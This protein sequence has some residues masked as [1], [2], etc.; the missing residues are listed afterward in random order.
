M[1]RGLFSA[2]LLATLVGATAEPATAQTFNQL[3]EDLF[4][5]GGRGGGRP[6]VNEPGMSRETRMQV[7]AGL[8][9]AGFY[10]GPIDGAIGQG[11]RAAI[12]RWQEANGIRPT[13]LL[14]RSEIARLR[15]LAGSFDG[16]MGGI[17][18]FADSPLDTPLDGA[19]LPLGRSETAELQRRLNELGYDAGSV[20]GRWGS[21][22]RQALARFREETGQPG[23]AD[24]T[25]AALVTVRAATGDGPARSAP[26]E[27]PPASDYA[28]VDSD[29]RPIDEVG[30][31]TLRALA[32]QAIAADPALVD[33][34]DEVLTFLGADDTLLGSKQVAEYRQANEFDRPRI[35]SAARARILL[36]AEETPRRPLKVAVTF[37]ASLLDFETGRGFPLEISSATVNPPNPLLVVALDHL[38]GRVTAAAAGLPALDLLPL[39]EKEGESFLAKLKRRDDLIGVVWADI[40]AEDIQED[41]ASER[42]RLS[43]TTTAASLHTRGPRVGT[44]PRLVLG[45]TLYRWRLASDRPDAPLGSDVLGLARELR[46][47]VVQDHL[48]MPS[49]G[50]GDDAVFN[51]LRV[52]SGGVVRAWQRLI[53]YMVLNENPALAESDENV[54]TLAAVHGRRRTSGQLNFNGPDPLRFA[55]EFERKAFLDRS[56]ADLIPSLLARKVPYPMPAAMISAVSL[57]EYDFERQGFS[58]GA[59]RSDAYPGVGSS[60]VETLFQG[61]LQL[62]KFLPMGVEEGKRFRRGLRGNTPT[63]Y[64]LTRFEITE[65]AFAQANSRNPNGMVLVFRLEDSILYADAALSNAIHRFGTAEL[66]PT[67][68]AP[69]ITDAEAL[70]GSL[71]LVTAR[72]LLD[73]AIRNGGGEPLAERAAAQSQVVK[74]AN[75]FDRSAALE[76]EKAAILRYKAA[77]ELWTAGE[78]VLAEYDGTG[79]PIP[80]STQTFQNDNGSSHVARMVNFQISNP[81]AIRR[82]DVDRETAKAGRTAMGNRRF[83]ILHRIR[84]VGVTADGDRSVVLVEALETI[85]W[86]RAD[87]D[88]PPVILARVRHD[89]QPLAADPDTV[90]IETA[91]RLPLTQEGVDLLRVKLD[92]QNITDADWQR[93]LLDRW[94]AERTGSAMGARFFAESLTVAPTRF[95]RDKLLS[96]FQ[97]WMRKRAEKAG[98]AVDLMTIA[99]YNS[100]YCSNLPKSVYLFLRPHEITPEIQTSLSQPALDDGALSLQSFNKISE[101]TLSSRLGYRLDSNFASNGSCL[102]EFSNELDRI[103]TE[104]TGSAQPKGAVVVIADA[105]GLIP[106][107]NSN[108][109]YRTARR[110]EG[111]VKS[112]RTVAGAKGVDVILELSSERTDYYPYDPDVGRGEASLG[113]KSFATVDHTALNTAAAAEAAARAEAERTATPFDIIGLTLGMDMA[114]AEKTIRA[115]MTVS[116]VFEKR[117]PFAA[118]PADMVAYGSAKAFI[119]DDGQEA[120]VVFNEPGAAPDKVVAV[121]RALFLDPTSVDDSAVMANLREKYG[122]EAKVLT[123]P[124]VTGLEGYWLRRP[125][126]PPDAAIVAC[127]QQGQRHDVFN[128]Q[129]LW[130][131][132]GVADPN[133]WLSN[134]DGTGVVF[135][136]RPPY[137]QV[138]PPLPMI[139]DIAQETRAS[140]DACGPSVYAAYKPGALA[141]LGTMLVDPARYA[142]LLLE[143]R[144]LLDSAATPG[145]ASAAPKV[146]LKL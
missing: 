27:L 30:G 22:S 41:A 38:G 101:P 133:P 128:V 136:Q 95:E 114:E 102:R 4:N 54:L 82:I 19:D 21:R 107:G 103:Y 2:I 100:F 62:P 36:E 48:L 50:G 43:A 121:S 111:R 15:D 80:E 64:V 138:P 39:G 3:F 16:N 92:P 84:P 88:K 70:I 42:I 57:G 126:D 59:N 53:D 83:Q 52:D 23:P 9:A 142:D 5:P 89:N 12:V 130:F 37:R 94:V 118:D 72:D 122:K 60:L 78:A 28:L 76:K 106:L 61:S 33:E 18:G 7:Q 143:S 71:R 8:S 34:D 85:V 132:N 1:R 140:L 105:V 26:R 65:T 120:I 134:A 46:I 137:Q 112:L 144:R 108:E 145:S 49:S 125:S 24:P 47:P 20:D 32:L 13:G 35:V 69:E 14:T 58:L 123:T 124:G 56:R 25:V 116:R 90:P 139:P 127:L 29:A 79:F 10:S 45:D 51:R 11:T 86:Y 44:G 110:I 40:S 98:D 75:E 77:E 97:S 87:Q 99:H 6:I 93:M 96:G 115:H 73:W 104:T 109:W 81:N 119:R 141:Y 55:D 129:G 74:E 67:P 135:N 113:D 117:R 17:D 146:K 63:L 91:D 131:E 68:D 66:N 31:R